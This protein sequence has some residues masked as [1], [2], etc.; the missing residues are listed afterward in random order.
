MKKLKEIVEKITDIKD[1]SQKQKAYEN[2]K[3]HINKVIE[4]INKKNSEHKVI[5]IPRKDE[6]IYETYDSYINEYLP[7]NRYE[8]DIS[9]IYLLGLLE[10]E[11]ILLKKHLQEEKEGIKG[12]FYLMEDRGKSIE[13]L[14]IIFELNRYTKSIKYLILMNREIKRNILDKNQS[15]SSIERNLFQRRGRLAGILTG[16]ERNLD[17]GEIKK[18]FTILNMSIPEN[19]KDYYRNFEKF[20]LEATLGE[21]N[22]E[23]SYS[24]KEDCDFKN[25]DIGDIV[26]YE[27]QIWSI[28]YK[29]ESKK[30]IGLRKKNET[31]T[32]TSEDKFNLISLV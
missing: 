28:V 17:I 24:I 1:T 31:R 11:Q 19:I 25:I 6:I 14:N 10:I 30:L 15:I 18:I 22:Y 4:E 5:G 21:G 3:Y 26:K 27:N 29:D 12:I 13:D 7:Q 32:I 23:I 8:K 20:K 2:I 16:K 9:I